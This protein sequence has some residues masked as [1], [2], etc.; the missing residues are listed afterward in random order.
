MTSIP[1]SRPPLACTV[2]DC[3]LFLEP[4]GRTLQCARRHAYDVARA[5]YVNLL[6]PQDRKS[7]VAGDRREAIE[8]RSRL[9]EEGI[10]R[11][12]GEGL[13]ERAARLVEANSV[14]SDLGSGSG[15][16][17]SMLAHR[18]PVMGIGIDLSTAAAEWAARRHPALTWVV[19]NADRRLPLL[20]RSVDLVLSL[21][22]R[23]NV[24]D[25]GRVLTRDGHL[26]VAV[27]AP[28]DLVELR[29]VVQGEGVTRDR[30]AGVIAEHESVFSVVDRSTLREHHRLGKTALRDLLRATYRGERRAWA[31]KLVAVDTLDITLATDVIVFRR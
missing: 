23:R 1:T 8:A 22:G 19:A 17:L 18:V 28:D 21:H 3:G 6:Q 5:G 27:P 2:R 13:I 15:D 16:V 26:L 14:V 20:D 24:A 25:C 9:L 7:R 12:I 29:A 30:V 4:H 10:G 11:P 31:E